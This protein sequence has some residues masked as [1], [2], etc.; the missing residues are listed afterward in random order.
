MGESAAT[1]APSGTD[2][3]IA[4]AGDAL[5]SDRVVM[6]TLRCSRLLYA[7]GLAGS[8]DDFPY[9]ESRLN[10]VDGV[11]PMRCRLI[12]CGDHDEWM[13][14][15]QGHDADV[16][17]CAYSGDREGKG[18]RT[19][20]KWLAECRPTM[21]IILLRLDD[22]GNAAVQPATPQLPP[23][24]GGPATFLLATWFRSD[25]TVRRGVEAH[26]E[27]RCALRGEVYTD[28]FERSN[29]ECRR[30]MREVFDEVPE[31]ASLPCPLPPC[32]RS[33]VSCVALCCVAP[34]ARDRAADASLRQ[35][36]R[37]QPKAARRQAVHDFMRPPQS[38]HSSHAAYIQL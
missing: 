31:T 21:P 4:L 14:S 25:R 11:R 28:E 12:E 17:I 33:P 32:T 2:V 30:Q 27:F 8:C 34:G 13:R 6:G 3:V 15:R 7:L 20:A 37:A 9:W 38:S 29:E 22:T 16:L 19:I 18:M 1:I 24:F 10:T 36:Q 35:K 26:R 23:L 5:A